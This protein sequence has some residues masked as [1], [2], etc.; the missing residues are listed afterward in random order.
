MSYELIVEEG[1]HVVHV[2]MTGTVNADMLLEAVRDMGARGVR[3]RDMRTAARRRLDLRQ[4]RAC[5]ILM[6]DA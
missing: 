1:A 3:A 4:W 6:G 2:R 5:R